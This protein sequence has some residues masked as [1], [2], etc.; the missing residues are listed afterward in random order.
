MECKWPGCDQAEEPDEK[1]G[2]YKTAPDLT[3]VDQTQ[4]DMKL[5]QEIHKA[6]ARQQE[7]VQGKPAKLERPKLE[8][9]SSDQ[10]WA[11]FCS[12]FDR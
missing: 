9:E 12:R 11:R 6:M 7:K 3:T 8:M 5:H 10:E 1:G 2:P 4:M